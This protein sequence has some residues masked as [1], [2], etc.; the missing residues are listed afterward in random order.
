MVWLKSKSKSL[1]FR[2]LINTNLTS[3]WKSIKQSIKYTKNNVLSN[4]T[5]N[6]QYS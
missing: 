2:H 5:L 4:Q 1:N 6:A 3:C